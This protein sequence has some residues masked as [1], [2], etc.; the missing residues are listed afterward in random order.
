M[1][2][3]KKFINN[4]DQ[5][6]IN[7]FYHQQFNS[8]LIAEKNF[9]NKNHFVSTNFK[10]YIIAN[11]HKTEYFNFINDIKTINT[12]GL[13][14][15]FWWINPWFYT[16][17]CII[18]LV[19]LITII[20]L[21]GLF[22]PKNPKGISILNVLGAFSIF[23]FLYFLPIPHYN[24]IK[25]LI[26]Y[27]YNL[28][29]YIYIL[30]S[31]VFTASFL[32]I[33]N[34]VTFLKEN[35]HIEY[36]ILIL[37][38]YISGI[39]AI[40]SENFIAVFLALESI[41]LISAVLIGFQRTNNLST[42]AS[43]RYIFF[44]AV[45]G[46]ALILGI[47]EIYAYT[48]AFNFSDIEKLLI[49]YNT[50][51]IYELNYNNEFIKQTILN[52]LEIII[53]H[54]WDTKFEQFINFN[55][56]EL[57]NSN[58]MYNNVLKPINITNDVQNLNINNKFNT[59][60]FNSQQ[61][62]ILEQFINYEFVNCNNENIGDTILALIGQSVSINDLTFDSS[63]KQ[64]KYTVYKYIDNYL[65]D[66]IADEKIINWVD[67]FSLN[68]I[69][70][71]P[72]QEK[73][74]KT[75]QNFINFNTNFFLNLTNSNETIFKEL[76]KQIF[77][78]FYEYNIMADINLNKQAIPLS[79]LKL[80]SMDNNIIGFLVNNLLNLTDNIP[81]IETLFSNLTLK[82]KDVLIFNSI[83]KNNTII[84]SQELY[85]KIYYIT[86]ILNLNVNESNVSNPFLENI[87]TT[88][89]TDLNN[90]IKILNVYKNILVNN[91]NCN[92]DLILND[93]NKLASQ[94][95]LNR[96][97]PF[98]DMY[99]LD[100]INNSTL[101]KDFNNL[102][103]KS[104]LQQFLNQ[105]KQLI[106]NELNCIFSEINSPTNLHE[107]N[108][109]DNNSE[110]IIKNLSLKFN[111]IINLNSQ[112]IIL[113]NYNNNLNILNINE[114][115]NE[116]TSNF[117]KKN[118]PFFYQ[119]LEIYLNNTNNSASIEKYSS[120]ENF[121]VYIN[122]ELNALKNEKDKI[123]NLLLIDNNK[124]PVIEQILLN[125]Y[126]KLS[127]VFE[128]PST[129]NLVELKNRYFNNSTFNE[130]D[131]SVIQSLIINMLNK[132][133]HSID[134]NWKN[135]S[136]FSKKEFTQIELNKFN[137]LYKILL[138]KKTNFDFNQNLN[139]RPSI[140]L[141]IYS[142]FLAVLYPNMSNSSK[143]LIIGNTLKNI[144]ELKDYNYINCNNSINIMN[145]EDFTNI[146]IISCGTLYLKNI[147]TDW[148]NTDFLN[149]FFYENLN[150]KVYKTELANYLKHIDYNTIID[151]H[152][153][154]LGDNHLY[155]I[156]LIINV[157]IFLI[158]FYILFKLTAAPFHIWA[159]SIY[160]G[161]PLPV[162]IFLSIFSKIT[163]IFL[164]MKLLILN[165]N[166]L[167]TEW[168]YI[169]IF[170]GLA[171]IV[172]GIYGAISETRIKRFFVYS[173]MGHVGFMLLGIAASGLH[174]MT[175]TILYLIIYTITVFIGWTILFT[176]NIKITHINQLNGLSKINPTL[177]FII[178]ISMLSMS[179]IPPLA[180][181]FVKFEVLYALVDSQYYSIVLIALLLTVF[182]FFYY[183]RII[184][185][186]YFEPLK[187]YR[188]QFNLNKTQAL[189]L[190]ICFL[191]LVNF[192]LYFQQPIVY[193]IKNIIIQS[194]Q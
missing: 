108:T 185:I 171:S 82:E 71:N 1:F 85:D 37:L 18:T 169:L 105:E 158:I 53:T 43:V 125:N 73:L 69:N 118:I 61:N 124:I 139:D 132:Y 58:Y 155:T 36:P 161:A 98:W 114:F 56:Q 63:I 50:S 159:P 31:G 20:F 162:A 35:K 28:F 45:P 191:L 193:Y 68:N 66:F 52:S 153:E 47:S 16:Y 91:F 44:S 183:L 126:I 79:N 178:A 142:N 92:K 106:I 94:M 96:K 80:I 26:W 100:L 147:Y 154:L 186:L 77:S 15:N 72:L 120:V 90:Q 192:S 168:S 164:L 117:Y 33:N 67:G 188:L 149:S 190:A 182:S 103:L 101:L 49:Q 87:Y 65:Y 55:Y 81:K 102:E 135:L 59:I 179:G 39:V 156:P 60:I 84:P 6:S 97:E 145:N 136:S 88:I 30:I 19:F 167:Y 176:S 41:T 174:G 151:G 64:G 181:F 2:D 172:V 109:I 7:S 137:D 57:N 152:L 115:C 112:L 116:L 165:F 180:G 42:L 148:V 129:T 9:F 74:V 160:E 144:F 86:N 138:D 10:D 157:S 127:S 22:L 113:N 83:S 177:S 38:T 184:K 14:T 133:G 163:M 29:V 122:S 24:A 140:L 123:N 48:G 95:E 34:E 134:G 23:L 150:N 27:D 32:A 93:L 75:N 146:F 175:S 143:Q 78:S 12:N 40:A 170:S 111:K 189:I 51:N 131:S 4:I 3:Y 141:N 46:G 13:S 8:K 173:S 21:I 107:L 121:L 11:L 17:N 62:N 128:K 110:E 5:D 119:K 166:F 187:S 130:N 104:F 76:S 99:I 89:L 70:K 194:I 54:S 25:N